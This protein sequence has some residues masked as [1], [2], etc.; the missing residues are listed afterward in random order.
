MPGNKASEPRR[1]LKKRE[2][3]AYYMIYRR[4]GSRADQGEILALLRSVF[5]RRTA[6][7]ILKRLRRAGLLTPLAGET[8]VYEVRDLH[9]YL[10]S[11]L[12]SYISMRKE[13]RSHS[14]S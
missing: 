1:W 11:L 8:L 12:S 2:F 13:R 5:P 4:L 9:E 10:D 7:N 14:S 6:R 3:L